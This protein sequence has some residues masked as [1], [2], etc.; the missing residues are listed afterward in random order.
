M[1][2][3]SGALMFIGYQLVAYG[4]SQLKGGNAGFFDILWPGKYKGMNADNSP[5]FSYTPT[6]LTDV[7]Q[8]G[9][10]GTTGPSPQSNPYNQNNSALSQKTFNQLGG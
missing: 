1:V 10:I 6:G 8:G 4:W 5:Q 3:V 7:A 9:T 2:A